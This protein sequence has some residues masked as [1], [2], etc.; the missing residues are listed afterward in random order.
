[1]SILQSCSFCGSF[2]SNHICSLLYEKLNKEQFNEKEEINENK[3]QFNENKEQFNE[4]KKENDEENKE[5]IQ[6]LID[7]YNNNEKINHY[8]RWFQE[9]GS[10]NGI[11]A[12]SFTYLHAIFEVLDLSSG[13]EDYGNL[14]DTCIREAIIENIKNRIEDERDKVLD[15]LFQSICDQ[16]ND[17]KMKEN[18]IKLSNKDENTVENEILNFIDNHK[19]I[20][21]TNY[22][23]HNHITEITN[24]IKKFL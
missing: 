14:T 11:K 17:T 6:K 20:N 10:I 24:H 7:E 21:F 12:D 16:L 19:Y 4:N 18:F 15:K 2:T 8:L 23:K 5:M 1:M 22:K 3:E 9:V 13:C